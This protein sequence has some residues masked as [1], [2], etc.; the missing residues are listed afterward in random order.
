[1]EEGDGCMNVKCKV[2]TCKVTRRIG[3]IFRIRKAC[4]KKMS[5]LSVNLQEMSGYE[6]PSFYSSDLSYCTI[7]ILYRLTNKYMIAT[8]N[9]PYSSLQ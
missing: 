9:G 3:S 8:Y 4:L 1:M 6:N 7:Y 5:V 2:F